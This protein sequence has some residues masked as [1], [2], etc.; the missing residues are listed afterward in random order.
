MENS[1]AKK[2]QNYYTK[3]NKAQVIGQ[4]VNVSSQAK[5]RGTILA[6]RLHTYFYSL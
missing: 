5:A 3:G 2:A 1:A 6:N 4:D